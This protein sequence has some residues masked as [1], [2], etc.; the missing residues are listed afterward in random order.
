ML[1]IQGNFLIALVLSTAI[2]STQVK[3][4]SGSS[5]ARD[6][7]VGVYAEI[8]TLV[9]TEEPL[10]TRVSKL[11]G[12]FHRALDLRT[13]S[14]LAA[15]KYW[16]RFEPGQLQAYKDVY[17]EYVVQIYVSRLVKE[18]IESID[19]VSS[20]EIASDEFIVTGVIARTGHPLL[21]LGFRVRRSEG[22]FKIID[23]TTD[24]VSLVMAQRNDFG[25]LLARDGLDNLIK[26]LR[27][28]LSINKNKAT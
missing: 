13:M 1:R 5:G 7:I 4:E 23:A 15:G 25:E 20:Q 3:A 14:R 22:I 10:P 27:K 6:F 18:T 19:I 26:A 11:E 9:A 24:G 17:A 28:K 8:M 12:L 21:T 16:Q 2:F